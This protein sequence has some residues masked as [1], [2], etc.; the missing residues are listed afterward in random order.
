MLLVNFLLSYFHED[1]HINNDKFSARNFFVS[2]CYPENIDKKK[3]PGLE[4]CLGS[5]EAQLDALERGFEDEENK[6]ETDDG[7]DR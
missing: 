6:R 3:L 1:I 2:C 7:L 4:N 5:V